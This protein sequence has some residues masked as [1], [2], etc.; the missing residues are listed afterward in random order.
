MLQLSVT[1][2][3]LG[4]SP[5]AARP[6]QDV[7]IKD[8]PHVVQRPDFCGEAAVEMVLKKHGVT[9][10]QDDVFAL[11]GLD[12][13]LGRGAYTIDLKR[14]LD[15]IG[16]ATGDVWHTIAADEAGPALDAE[17]T[18]LHADLQA[19]VPSIVC[20]RF[21]FAPNTTEHFRLVLG[22]DAKRDEVIFH[23]PALKNGASQRMRRADFLS[24]WPL[25][26][27]AD[28]WTVIRLRLEP[29]GKLVV[30]RRPEPDPA[31]YAQHV[32]ALRERLGDDANDFTI[33][34]QPPF[35]VLGNQ[36]AERVKASAKQIVEWTRTR[37]RAQYF[38]KDPERILDVWL[39]RD[40]ETYRKW[41][42][43]VSG[44]PPDTPYGYYSSAKGALVMNIAT[45]GGTLVHEMVHAFMEANFDA[46]AWLNEGLGSLY[47]QS[48]ERDGRII[49]L[50]N[51][52]LA[53]LQAAVREG[54][55]PT[56]RA[57]TGT[58]TQQF[59]FED[60]GTNYAQ[61]RY[62]LYYLQERDL[63]GDYWAA[64][65][66]NR[67]TDPTGYASLQKVLGEKDMAAWQ[68]RWEAWV[69]TLRFP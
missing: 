28:N 46:P 40:A 44:D 55:V 23:D 34:V 26:Y 4:A 36:S 10:T 25:K 18:G 41:A 49:G 56:F 60:P 17:W 62:L 21:S 9:G 12:P 50:T 42:V 57:L 51:W 15:R 22:Y 32:L 53:G 58:T 33:V 5:G 39:L 31:A 16:F 37:L 47:E 54:S 65:R 6:W 52:R 63:L 68:K 61:A 11:T 27:S 8:V 29:K 66:K 19:G 30:P 64:L 7:L 43:E 35:V 67:K 48:N 24:L 13:A 59:Y 1:L 3:L 38:E 14:A 69:L 2:L 20:T 45:G